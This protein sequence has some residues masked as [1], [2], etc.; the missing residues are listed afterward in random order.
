VISLANERLIHDVAFGTS[1]HILELFANR[2]GEEEA[3]ERF[4][5]IYERIKAG[6][7]WLVIKNNRMAQHLDPGRN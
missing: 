1:L 7:E 3:H 6:I 4:A 2:L 5:E